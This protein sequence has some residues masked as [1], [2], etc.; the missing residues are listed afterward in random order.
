MGKYGPSEA[1]VFNGRRYRRYPESSH[2]TSRVYFMRTVKS[3]GV[4][5]PE[6]LHRAIWEHAN[7]AVPD[8]SH[9]HHADE[10]PLN[11]DIANLVLRNGAEHLREHAS[12]PERVALSKA[13]LDVAREHAKKWHGSPEGL[14]WHAE[15]GRTAMAG[16]TLFATK[17]ERCGVEFQT[18]WLR[19][20]TCSNK[21]RAALRR[22]SGTDDEDRTCPE[23]GLVY[24]VNRY[25]RQKC[26]S[27]SCASRRTARSA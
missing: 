17:C 4:S 21:C 12:T 27:H 8:G 16:R 20:K 5:R 14:A 9:V 23:C 19:T 18:K 15:H 26:C 10:N 24:R 22:A 25:E 2:R 7:G 13:N 3:G 1:V 11:N 6:S